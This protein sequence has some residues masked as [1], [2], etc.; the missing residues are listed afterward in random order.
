MDYNCA[1]DLSGPLAVIYG[2]HMKSGKMF[3]GLKGYKSQ[4]YY[5]KHPCM[6]LYSRQ[7]GYR[8]DLLYGFVIEAGQWKEGAF[9]YPENVG[10]LMKYAAL[11]TTFESGLKYE[12]GDKIAALSTCSYEFDDA[13]YVVVGRMEPI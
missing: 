6:Y 1:P 2:H 7:G 12:E 5:E 3:G 8:I 13:R 11:N 9:M 10:G 4:E